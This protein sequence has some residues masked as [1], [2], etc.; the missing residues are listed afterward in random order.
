MYFVLTNDE[1]RHE[2]ASISG[3]D[4]EPHADKQDERVGPYQN[5]A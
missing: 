2:D 4:Q 5:H 1:A 3:A